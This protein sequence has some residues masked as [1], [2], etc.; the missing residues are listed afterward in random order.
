[1]GGCVFMFV[2]IYTHVRTYVHMHTLITLLA[3]HLHPLPCSLAGTL[4]RGR[5]RTS[6]D[7]SLHQGERPGELEG[8]Q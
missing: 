3:V 8:Q 4:A 6:S 1:M 5:E 2:S 7:H